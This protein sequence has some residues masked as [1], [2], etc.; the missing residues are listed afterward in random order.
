MNTFLNDREEADVMIRPEIGGWGVEKMTRRHFRHTNNPG[1]KELWGFIANTIKEF[2]DNED[3]L[4]AQ[5]LTVTKIDLF[6]GFIH[7]RAS[8][9]NGV[10]NHEENYAWFIAFMSYWYR[11]RSGVDG[12]IQKIMP[13]NQEKFYNTVKNEWDAQ[14]ENGSEIDSLLEYVTTHPKMSKNPYLTIPVRLEHVRRIRVYWK[15]KPDILNRCKSHLKICES[16]LKLRAPGRYGLTCSTIPWEFLEIGYNLQRHLT[17]G[18]E[19]SSIDVEAIGNNLVI[20]P[21]IDPSDTHKK[22]Y[23][24]VV[25]LWRN[26]LI[27][28]IFLKKLDMSGVED[29]N[30][31]IEDI[32]EKARDKG[33]YLGGFLLQINESSKETKREGSEKNKKFRESSG[34]LMVEYVKEALTFFDR[35]WETYDVRKTTVENPSDKLRDSIY[36]NRTKTSYPVK[37]PNLGKSLA[38]ADKFVWHKKDP[39]LREDKT[40]SSLINDCRNSAKLALFLLDKIHLSANQRLNRHVALVMWDLMV[41]FRWF[42]SVPTFY[43]PQNKNEGQKNV[44]E[45]S[46]YVEKHGETLAIELQS[47]IDVVFSKALDVI[48][49]QYPEDWKDRYPEGWKDREDKLTRI[50][51]AWKDYINSEIDITSVKPRT[52]LGELR[53][54]CGNLVG[55]PVLDDCFSRW[56]N[57]EYDSSSLNDT[58][59]KIIFFEPKSHEPW[60]YELFFNKENI[61][62]PGYGERHGEVGIDS[63][64]MD[65]ITNLSF[66]S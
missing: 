41:K 26:I 32:I 44:T 38:S 16:E 47:T 11:N 45:A 62:S 7:S 3:E 51:K 13:G 9:E 28:R 54:R 34:G 8:S 15:K 24:Q 64:S 52:H 22:N 59:Q 30:R 55:K 37:S 14:I 61:E 50:I 60:T 58:E 57:P 25:D 18:R 17:L 53:A 40:K 56:S 39:D 6:N 27:K 4:T 12:A 36:R 42:L 49:S 29:Q 31:E 1:R 2:T 65:N 5:L 48:D 33:D 19:A 10:Q 46:K 63:S 43:K 21:N 35:D 66:S 20:G 23:A